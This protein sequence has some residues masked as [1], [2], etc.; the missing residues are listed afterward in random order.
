MPTGSNE[1]LTYAIR[2]ESS[3]PDPS[4]LAR[5]PELAEHRCQD[6]SA[7]DVGVAV[8]ANDHEANGT[9]P[10]HML[11]QQQCRLVGPVQIIDHEQ[12]R[13]IGSALA[14]PRLD[15]PEQPVA[16]GVWLVAKWWRQVGN[17]IPQVGHQPVEVAR[18][19]AE[20]GTVGRLLTDKPLQRGA[21]RLER[22]A[23]LVAPS[24][25]HERY[26]LTLRNRVCPHPSS[27]FLSEPGLAD[28]RLAGQQDDL[29][30]TGNTRPPRLE[31]PVED[32]GPTRERKSRTG[33]DRRKGQVAIESL[34]N[35]LP[36]HRA[37]EEGIGET[38][39][40]QCPQ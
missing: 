10:D 7:V 33:Q 35:R 34:T 30:A 24:G 36:A 14:Q 4:D 21:E 23:V 16:L 3:D 5:G 20:R 40:R 15:R 17:E 8:G 19:L 9:I 22:S 38:L 13:S 31:Q 26:D 6:V 39:E 11:Q 1:Q 27:E 32:L 25:Q 12:S 18:E 28:A 29:E 2:P 37:R